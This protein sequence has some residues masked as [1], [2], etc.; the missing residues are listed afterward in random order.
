MVKASRCKLLLMFYSNSLPSAKTRV[1]SLKL[2]GTSVSLTSKDTEQ[3]TDSRIV[4]QG[5]GS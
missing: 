4:T 5:K 1:L 3:W 2:Q